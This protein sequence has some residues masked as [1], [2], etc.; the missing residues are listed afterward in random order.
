MGD[1]GKLGFTMRWVL[2]LFAVAAVIGLGAAV[3]S[4]Q[5]QRPHTPHTP[6]SSLDRIVIIVLENYRADKVDPSQIE[7]EQFTP[8]LNKLARENRLA[9]NYFGV[10]KPSLPNYLAMIAGDFF[11]VSDDHESCFSPDHQDCHGFDVPN[12][13]DQLEK[14]HIAWEGLFESMPS[15]G[16]LG[17]WFPPDTKLYAQK[18]NPFVYF[19]SIALDPMRLAKL[20]PF[21]LSDLKA[22]LT[23]PVSASRFI[24]IVPNQCNDQHGTEGCR[25]KAVKLAAGDAFLAE[26]VPAIINAP[27]FTDRSVLFITWDNSDGKEACCGAQRGGGRI[28]LIAVTQ[29]ARVVRGTTPSDHYS[30]L[31]TI[32]DGFG[33]PRLTNAAHSA[34]VFDLLPD[35]AE[36]GRT[37]AINGP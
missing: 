28:P 14:A 21:V 26:T 25:G 35:F 27:A 30:L 32:E 19:K 16:V 10:W 6:S 3:F 33:L 31:A 12:L 8:F 1:L 22:E 24:Y 17:S 20:K 15:A 23:D 4:A 37:S 34:T 18:H 11:G 29:Q 2:R 13:V 36:I 7:P 9:T 5:S